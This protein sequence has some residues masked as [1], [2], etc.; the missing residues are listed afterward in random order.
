MPPEP[1]ALILL[2]FFLAALCAALLVWFLLTLKTPRHHEVAEPVRRP[3]PPQFA[4]KPAEGTPRP[5]PARGR[6][7]PARP[8]GG[9]TEQPRPREHSDRPVA[10]SVQP[11]AQLQPRTGPRQPPQTRPSAVQPAPQPPKRSRNPKDDPFERFIHS[12]NDDLDF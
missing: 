5:L 2:F 12:K 4:A 11:P 9:L 10:R 8:G 6:A 3:V 7:V 1:L